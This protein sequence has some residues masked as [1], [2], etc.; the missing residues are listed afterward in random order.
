MLALSAKQAK[1]VVR[2]FDGSA[3]ASSSERARTEGVTSPWL[4]RTVF[5]AVG[6]ILAEDSRAL[7]SLLADVQRA[8]REGRLFRGTLSGAACTASHPLSCGHMW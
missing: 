1:A 3:V 2:M 7:R 4:L 8:A 5:A 6:T